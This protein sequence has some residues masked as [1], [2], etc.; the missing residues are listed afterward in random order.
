MST[1]NEA[2]KIVPSGWSV[3]RTI[4]VSIAAIAVLVAVVA[5]AA[6]VV[7][8]EPAAPGMVFTIPEG[9][10]NRVIPQMESAIQIPTDIVFTRNDEAAITIINEDDV[11]HRAGP[12]LIGPGQTYIQRF[13]EP[14]AY[15]IACTVDPA[16]SIVVTVEG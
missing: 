5:G 3:S 14:G 12:F 8:D 9:S 7:R 2:E 6:M 13:D 10:K 11:T 16:E 1:T 4:V 15:P